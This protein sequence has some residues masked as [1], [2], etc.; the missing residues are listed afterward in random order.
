MVMERAVDLPAL[1]EDA[2]GIGIGRSVCPLVFA[3]RGVADEDCDSWSRA[4][5]AS[6]VER[7]RGARRSFSADSQRNP[8]SY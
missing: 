2:S 1:G 5:C 3:V 7:Q 4:H 6:E 8:A